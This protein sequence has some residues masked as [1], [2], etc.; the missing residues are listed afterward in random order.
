M[1]KNV[2][3]FKI[4]LFIHVTEYHR[5]VK[6]R[7]ITFTSPRYSNLRSSLSD[8]ATYIQDLDEKH[9]I[10]L[11]ATTSFHYLVLSPYFEITFVIYGDFI[12][13]DTVVEHS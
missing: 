12:H 2:S 10:H 9:S 5:G 13:V 4:G 1:E 11:H 3:F 8:V 6:N 7:V